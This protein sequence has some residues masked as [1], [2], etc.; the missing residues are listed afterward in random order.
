MH[1]RIATIVMSPIR[2]SASA[3]RRR[4]RSWQSDRPASA[5]RTI[6]ASPQSPDATRRHDESDRAGRVTGGSSLNGDRGPLPAA[7]DTRIPELQRLNDL[8]PAAGERH[9]ETNMAAVDR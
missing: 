7:A 4:S 6:E 8:T 1:P 9:D 3:S 2:S 5:I